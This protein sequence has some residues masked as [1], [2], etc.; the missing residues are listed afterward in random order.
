MAHRKHLLA[1]VGNIPEG[2]HGRNARERLARDMA[3]FLGGDDIGREW[4]RAGVTTARY[5]YNLAVLTR[6]R[7]NGVKWIAYDVQPDAC[8]SCKRL[9]LHGDGLPRAFSV[10]GIWAQIGEDG[11]LNI[12][13]KATRIG[14][15]DGWRVGI[16]IHP[17]CRC[18]PRK[19]KRVEIERETSR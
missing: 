11:G 5:A 7:E 1:I 17:W 3:S 18:R 4:E 12:G 14:R 8:G 15:E 13:R 10:Q 16:V 9:L 19:A 2:G 6:M